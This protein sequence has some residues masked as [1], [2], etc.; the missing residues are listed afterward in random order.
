MEEVAAETGGPLTV[1]SVADYGMSNSGQ[2]HPDLVSPAGVRGD[3]KQGIAVMGADGLVA[4][5]GVPAAL[6]YCHFLASGEVP[7]Y[8]RLDDA[9]GR[10][11]RTL[12]ERYI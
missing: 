10:I 9:F 2:V 4:G 12:N 8:G 3:A 11:N 6:D 7:A 5:L 1:C